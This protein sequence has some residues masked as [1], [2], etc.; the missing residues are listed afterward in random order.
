MISIIEMFEQSVAK[1]G[2]NVYMWEKLKDKYQPTSYSQT[3]AKVVDFAIGLIGLGV[4]K[5]D[6]ISLLSEARNDWVISELSILYTGAICV[7]LS[8]KLEA[9]DLKFRI[10]HSESKIVI[11][12]KRQFKLIENIYNEFTKVER[13]IILDSGNF[14]SEKIV[15]KKWVLDQISEKRL[16]AGIKISDLGKNVD[17]DDIACISYTSGTTAEPKGILLSHRNFTANVEQSLSLIDIPQH[18]R[19]LLI[20]PL[21]HSF[22]HTSGIYTFMKLGASIA[23]V[24]V[25]DTVLQTLKNVKTNIQEIKP[26]VLLSVPALAKNFR[27]GIEDGIKKQG[28]TKL[29][30]YA[31]SL[32]YQYNKEGYNKGAGLKFWIKPQLWLFDKIMFSKIRKFFGGELKFFVGGGALLDIE[33]Q[34]FYYALGIPMF[35][36]YGLSEASPVISTNSGRKHKLGSSGAIVED[37]E[38]K[39]CDSDGNELPNNTSG[40]IVISGENVMK[41]YYK[42]DKDTLETIKDDWLYTGDMGYVDDDGF[43]Y[44]LGRYKSLLISSDGEKYS[45]EQIEESFN[46]ESKYIDQSMLHNNQNPYTVGLIVPNKVAIISAIKSEKIDL[47]SEEAVERALDMVKSEIDNYKS[48]G[49]FAGKFPERW[50]PSTFSVL[51]QQFTEQ[52]KFLNSTLKMVRRNI[53]EHYSQ[54]IEFLYT[55]DSKNHLNHINKSEMKILLNS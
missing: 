29:F 17:K 52:N 49:K 20:L 13:I 30:N 28:M 6:K 41:G 25:G 18:Y 50:L 5:G 45:P 24:Q 22:A 35:Q 55:P 7:P 34:R 36:G 11:V 44:V 46:E 4:N 54:R 14:E 3:K 9:T 19:T 33:L 39:I 47:K 40:E 48:G 10:N 8:T 15:T 1:Y 16:E 21:D 23:T 42:N 53:S 12:S 2:D 51:S 37:M 43:L 27:K 31:L 26:H 32:A 38:L